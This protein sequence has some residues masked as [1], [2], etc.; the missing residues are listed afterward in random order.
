MRKIVKLLYRL[1]DN[2]YTTV[3]LKN[4]RSVDIK[5]SEYIFLFNQV[6]GTFAGKLYALI[7]HELSKNGIA[8]YFL[9]KTDI[10][11]T[12]YN[13]FNIDGY[14]I[15]NA[16]ILEKERYIKSLTPLNERRLFFEWIVNIENQ[17][18]EAEGINFF[19][20]IRSTLRIIQ[21]RYNVFY[22]DEN[23]SPV[24]SNLIQ[25]C[26]LLLKYFLLLKDYS[27][28]ND[29]KIRLVGWEANYIP[30]GVFKLL[31]DLLTHNRDIEYIDLERGYVGY[32]GQ[33]HFRESYITCSNLTKANTSFGW[34]VLKEELEEFDAQNIDLHKLLK[35]VANAL[36]KDIYFKIPENQKKVIKTIEDYRS[37][38]KKVFVLF[39][40]LFYDIPIDEKS[41][42]FHGMCDWIKETVRYFYGKEHLLL[43]KPHPAEIRKDIPKKNPNEKLD[44]FLSNIELSENVILLEPR[45]FTVKDLSPYMSCGLIWSSSVAMELVFLGMPYIIAGSPYYN[46]L[47]LNFAKDKEHYFRMIEQSHE[48]KVTEK[49]KINVARYLYLIEN[50]HVHIDCISYDMKMRKIY[51]NRKALKKYLKNGNQTIKSVVENMLV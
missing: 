49:H 37:L 20:I 7:S 35:P 12:Y 51:W 17:K 23:N 13:R 38:G 43:I 3:L 40:N 11:S 46:I 19:P 30:N 47:D 39:S 22:S 29:K 26:D 14:E 2:Y 50:K 1:L 42:A 6:R 8:S 15:S 28:K 44:S 24:Y 18:I 45:L 36:E 21:K 4:I 25:S 9:Y 32:F 34:S 5:N 10:S 41:P 31:C 48:I 16:F 33:H 27:Q